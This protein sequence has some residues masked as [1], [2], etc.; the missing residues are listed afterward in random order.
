MATTRKIV[1]GILCLLMLAQPSSAASSAPASAPALPIVTIIKEAIKKVIKAIDLKVQRLQNK[2]VWLQNTQ[3]QIENELHRLKLDEI[4]DWSRKQKELYQ[5]YYEELKKV[6]DIVNSYRRIREI[7]QKQLRLVEAYQ[8]AWNLILQDSHFNDQEI[9]HMHRVYSGI[10]ERSMANVE[11]ISLILESYSL[12]MSDAE[13]LQI[14]NAVSDDI[15]RNYDDLRLFNKQNRL[16]SLQRSKTQ[17][18]KDRIRQLY[19]PI[20]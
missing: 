2:T 8:T 4:S 12:Q 19:Q 20:D 10:L 17:Q 15:D 6:K 11:Q 7:T 18:D 1:I 5:N 9:A 3:K 14:I 13:R 16:L